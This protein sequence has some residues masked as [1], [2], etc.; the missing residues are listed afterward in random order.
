MKEV[1]DFLNKAGVYFL[2]TAYDDQPHVRPIGFVMDY[3]GK[4]AFCTG[5][6]K[7][8]CK[9]LAANPKIEIACYD[10]Q[11]NTLRIRG[12]AVF[13]T[14]EE[15]QRRAFEVMPALS[16]MYAVGDGIFEIYYL[17]DATALCTNMRGELQELTIQVT[18][19]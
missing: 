15:T 17:D 7:S 19:D 9:Q 2:A 16:G 14:S 10:G 18:D 3:N 1:L 6:N 8:M 5:N 11:G 12:K 4:L 13:A